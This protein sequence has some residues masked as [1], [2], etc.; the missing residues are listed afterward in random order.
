V[1]PA[2]GAV[3]VLGE[4]KRVKLGEGFEASRVKLFFAG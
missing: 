1:Q 2:A 3:A 4:V